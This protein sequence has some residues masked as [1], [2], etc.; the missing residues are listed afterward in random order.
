MKLSTPHSLK[1][2]QKLSKE[3]IT[4]LKKALKS[5]LT[6]TQKI[7]KEAVSQ[8]LT[9]VSTPDPKPQCQTTT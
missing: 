6:W 9:Q 3:I 2:G 8:I 1:R 4:S 7:L 5:Q